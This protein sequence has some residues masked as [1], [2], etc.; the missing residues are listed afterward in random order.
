MSEFQINFFSEVGELFVD[1]TFN[2]D[3]YISY[4]YKKF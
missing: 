3:N 4:K 1:G 2:S